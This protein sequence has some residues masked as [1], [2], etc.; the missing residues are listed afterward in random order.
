EAE[1]FEKLN[2]L[3]ADNTDEKTKW[4]TL[5]AESNETLAAA[6]ILN[7]NDL[8]NKY[9]NTGDVK[10]ATDSLNLYLKYHILY[11]A[12]YLSDIVSGSAHTT[13]APLEVLTSKLS[14]EKVLINDDIFNGVRE[15][16]FELLRS[17]SDVS[18]TN[19]VIHQANAHFN[20]KIR[21]PYRVDFDVCTF[22]EMI[23]NSAY[24]GKANYFF[25]P[26]EAANLS[27][28]KFSH[29]ME[30]ER[31]IYRYGSGQGTS[32]TSYNYDV[33]VVPLGPNGAS[34]RPKWVDFK[35]PLLVKG[36]YKVWIGYY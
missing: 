19:G 12:K 25:T 30:A 11:D 7:Y 28:I 24:Y 8:K 26:E 33:L 36:K 9:S 23:K 31:F 4:L 20:I 22:P 1:L 29:G 13:L 3:P 16:G 32:K 5:I 27:E 6:G 10:S 35:T 14:V 18:S 21:K 15:N 17:T 34:N 2:V